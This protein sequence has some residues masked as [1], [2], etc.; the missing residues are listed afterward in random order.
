MGR[1]DRGELS[2]DLQRV[3][4][5]FAAWRAGRRPGDRIPERLWKQ[6]VKL[7]GKHGIS[8]TSSALRLDYYSLKERLA[9]SRPQAES[10][11]AD[12]SFVELPAPIAGEYSIEFED[13]SGASMRV[14]IKGGGVPD[15]MAL[16]RSF[17][18]VD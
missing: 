13:G 10:G 5:Q 9:Q 12:A 17:W 7:A 18:N 2:R 11:L 16:S 4:G 8:H 15:L 14:T 3:Q 1:R 6:A